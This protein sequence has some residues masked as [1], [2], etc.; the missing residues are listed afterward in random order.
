MEA[1]QKQ[2][3]NAPEI[4]LHFLDYWRIIRIRKTVI[5]AVFLLVAITTTLVTFI[6]PESF[7]SMVRMK[8]EKDTLDVPGLGGERAYTGFD[9]YWVQDQFE[10]IQSKA[11]LYQVITNLSLNHSWA[12]KYKE[13]TDLRTEVTYLLLKSKIDVRQ[14][15]N[16]S[17]IE[18]KVYSDDKNEAAAIANEIAIVYRDHRLALRKEMASGGLK[19]LQEKLDQQTVQVTNL[20]A[21]IEEMKERLGISDIESTVPGYA[22]QTL[23]PERLRKTDALR[24]ESLAEYTQINTLY[25]NLVNLDRTELKKAILTVQKDQPLMELV[26]QQALT[27]QKI[28]DLLETLGVDHPDV[29]RYKAVLETI[30]RKMDSRL[31]GIMTGLKAQR[32]SYKSKLDAMQAEVDASKVIDIKKSNERRPYIQAKR[33]LENHE[34][35]RDKL[36]MRVLQEEVEAAI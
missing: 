29:K 30:N 5:L 16:T 33:D 7:A 28:A 20:Q 26:G 4:K 6:L 25:S 13:E 9:P 10:T 8:V 21:R 12:Q 24:I 27:E 3:F 36:L 22:T 19:V 34:F 23:E 35:I 17:L 15:R 18:V 31:E 1:T 11:I 2:T 32:D 14:A